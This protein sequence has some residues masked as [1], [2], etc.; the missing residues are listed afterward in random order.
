[1]DQQIINDSGQNTYIMTNILFYLSDY[2][3]TIYVIISRAIIATPS[4]RRT[5]PPDGPALRL[6]FT[7]RRTYV[8]HTPYIQQTNARHIYNNNYN[9]KDSYIQRKLEQ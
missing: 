7:V 8:G 5:G 2:V 9:N 1:M 6:T 4:V 3:I